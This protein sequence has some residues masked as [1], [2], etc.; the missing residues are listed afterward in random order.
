MDDQRSGARGQMCHVS[1]T[2]GRERDP[3]LSFTDTMS[4]MLEQKRA[5]G[6]AFSISLSTK[7]QSIVLSYGEE[8]GKSIR[9]P[10]MVSRQPQQAAQ[11]GSR[12]PLPAPCTGLAPARLAFAASQV[13]R[14][15]LANFW[16]TTRA[17]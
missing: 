1:R 6:V 8:K 10:S 15:M 13:T 3:Y 7:D 16:R 5:L 11:A 9:A 2:W 12:R 4:M 14:W 17:A